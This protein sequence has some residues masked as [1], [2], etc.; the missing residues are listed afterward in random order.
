LGHLAAFLSGPK[1]RILIV[2]GAP[3]SGKSTILR[4]IASRLKGPIAFVAY[5]TTPAA[6]TGTAGAPEGVPDV[7]LLLVDPGRWASGAP[8]EPRDG[9]TVPLSFAPTGSHSTDPFPSALRATIERLVTAGGGCVVV[10]S[11]DRGTEET[12]RTGA[13]ADSVQ[14]GL[15][16]SSRLMRDQLGRIPLHTL[17]A[18]FGTPDPEIESLA[19][20][21]VE[22]GSVA[23]DGAPV[24]QLS[25]PK[26]RGASIPDTHFLFSLAGGEFFTPSAHAPGY[27]GPPT[28]PEAEG[29]AEVGTIWP[30]SAEYARAF[31][32]MRHNGLTAFQLV[33][34]TPH[35]VVDALAAPVA[36][37]VIRAGGRVVWAPPG[38]YAP[39]HVAG[40]LSRFLS[41]EALTQGLRVLSASRS[42]PALG[43]LKAVMLPVTRPKGAGATPTKATGDE[44]GVP[45][46]PDAYRFLRDRRS[47]G[48][49]LFVLS[50][51]ALAA[52]S[53][54]SGVLY[55]PATFPMIVA[56][57][58]HLPRFHGLGFAPNDHPLTRALLPAVST[59]LKVHQQYGRTL[60]QGVRPRTPP[61]LLD[62]NR[63]DGRYS[64][65]PML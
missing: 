6:G 32:R 10:D 21:L 55:E 49:A 61:Y 16:A 56:S 40:L 42:D 47:D 54:V 46:F 37:A 12:F 50:L 31:G 52:L 2:R 11:W 9:T 41:P 35:G 15:L 7:S 1:P 5:R 36:A 39:S 19:D 28:A 20:G 59:D 45:L 57:Y 62:W 8:L 17:I 43:D 44:A 13:S 63:P 27:V 3:G 60:I 18:M 58:A 24:R 65:V 14:A 22:L 26:F 4:A 51:E 23:V 53:A 25:L 38:A 34:D 48:P 33:G 29:D 64:L 30:G